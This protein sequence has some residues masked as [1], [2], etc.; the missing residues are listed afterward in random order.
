MKD[1]EA[2]KLE[3]QDQDSTFSL[4]RERR[5][6]RIMKLLLSMVLNR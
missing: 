3:E 6:I 1:T 5:G 4:E 2:K